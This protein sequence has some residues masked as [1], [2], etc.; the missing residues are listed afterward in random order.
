MTQIQD[1]T[2]A[3][4][5]I[6]DLSSE[7]LEAVQRFTLLWTLFEAQILESN[8]SVKMISEKVGNIK[9]EVLTGEWLGE[10]L[11]YFSK[12]YIEDG[13]TNYHFDQLHLRKNDNPDLVRS[14]LTGKKVDPASQLIVCLTIVYRFR[15]N[16]FH[17]IK[18]AYNL[19]GQLDNFTH[20]SCLLLKCLEKMPISN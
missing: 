8:A 20:A 12:R 15:N 17:G 11:T 5:G 13:E 14:V 18:W 2:R 4:P 7:E 1:A 6:M 16:F 9:L 19:Q 10:Y 3:A